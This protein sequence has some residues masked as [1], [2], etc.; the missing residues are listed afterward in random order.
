MRTSKFLLRLATT[1]ALVSCTGVFGGVTAQASAVVACPNEVTVSF[2]SPLTTATH[3]GVATVTYTGGCAEAGAGLSSGLVPVF[4][5]SNVYVPG[6]SFSTGAGYSGTCALA[7][8]GGPFWAQ[9]GL[10]VGGSVLVG[11][12]SGFT[13]T[14]V[15]VLA[16]LTPCNEFT[17][18]GAGAA[19][20][21]FL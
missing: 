7:T 2:P 17:A 16:P 6:Q 11:E 5:S 9:P 4:E 8:M 10:L 12:P 3:A 19:A 18:V 15:D 21:A 14:E 20:G 13:A 1:V